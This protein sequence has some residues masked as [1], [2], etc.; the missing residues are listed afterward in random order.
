MNK[1]QSLSIFALLILVVGIW[2]SAFGNAID[3]SG[4]QNISYLPAG[5]NYNQIPG[6]GG[7]LF[8][9]QTFTTPSVNLILENVTL[10]NSVNINS[11]NLFLNI[12]F[13]LF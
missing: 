5:D 12:Y 3:W 4:N 7:Q 9:G 13:E 6:G 10:S 2:F 11:N 8:S 1:Y